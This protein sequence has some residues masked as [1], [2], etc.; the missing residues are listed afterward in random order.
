M[1][2]NYVIDAYCV[3]NVI[4]AVF[5]SVRTNRNLISRYYAAGVSMLISFGLFSY[6]LS[7][8]LPSPYFNVLELLLLFLFSFIPFYFLHLIIIFIGHNSPIRSRSIISSLYLTAGFSFIML[9]LGFIPAPFLATGTLAANG[10]IF[11]LTW[12]SI[13]FCLGAAQVYSIYSRYMGRVRSN[14]IFTGFVLLLLIVPGPFSQSI[15]SKIFN[16]SLQ[17]YFLS[18]M[19]AL[20]VSIYFIFRHNNVLN[21]YGAL[22]SS[23]AAMNDILV[24]TDEN[25]VIELMKGGLS[26]MTGYAEKE[27]IGKYL[28]DYVTPRELLIKYGDICSSGDKTG[29]HWEVNFTVKDDH[30]IPISLS[31]TP[32]D[33]NGVLTGHA[34]IIRDLSER[35]KSEEKI[36]MLYSAVEQSPVSIIV[37]DGSGKLLYAN[38]QFTSLSGF[39]LSEIIGKDIR[40][41][42][43]TGLSDEGFNE[44]I[45]KINNGSDWKGEYLNKRRDGS[46]Y[47]ESIS[48]STLKNIEDKITHYLIMKED[49][50]RKKNIEKELRRAKESAEES[51]RMKTEFLA[52][53]THEIRTP[54]NAILSFSSLLK[55]E[56]EDKLPK[57]LEP[58]FESILSSGKRLQRTVELILNMASLQSG[59]IGITPERIDI[60]E[61]IKDVVTGYDSAALK[62]ELGLSFRKEC[63]N[64]FVETDKYIVSQ[65]LHNLLD[66]AIK[67][68]R[69]GNVS[70]SLTDSG[71]DKLYVAVKDTGIGISKKYIPKLFSKFSQQ[72]TGYGRR[73][74]GNG[75]GLA[76]VK[77]FADLIGAEIS[78][79][80]ELGK[81]SEFKV[82][83][84]KEFQYLRSVQNPNDSSIEFSTPK[85]S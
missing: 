72:E 67:F 68:T 30:K 37:A 80:S 48:I 70:V 65:I 60:S 1:L 56:T 41:L 45:V 85:S 31:L 16:N 43:P 9:V 21:L 59:D 25:F 20:I 5:I 63:V 46:L 33:D 34:G 2:Y 36:N 54:L 42:K 53:M 74:E 82:I 84:N 26:Q 49:T 18:S 75:L 19:F 11:Y 29:D 76:L 51:D 3:V 22:K 32:I 6:L 23:L 28:Y 57:E 77:S 58:A 35:I 7:L 73:F 71:K 78:V 8:N 83:F 64:S 47:W 27:L 10:Y 44:L 81:G 4:L 62:K 24:K 50:T 55:N 38:P 12:L 39:D 52:Q 13:I 66:N 14:I 79:D 17:W 40:I 15:I 61:T 69:R